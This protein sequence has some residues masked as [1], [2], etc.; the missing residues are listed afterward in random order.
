[1]FFNISKL[2]IVPFLILSIK[3]LIYSIT[4]FLSL[5][6]NIT[7]NKEPVIIPNITNIKEFQLLHTNRLTIKPDTKSVA[8]IKRVE[9]ILTASNT[10]M[11]YANI[12]IIGANIYHI[13]GL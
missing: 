4:K 7:I 8:N 3:L 13:K 6:L 1:M 12:F 5:L 2:L 10:I 11:S 9:I